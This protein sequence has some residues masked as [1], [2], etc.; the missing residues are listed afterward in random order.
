MNNQRITYKQLSMLKLRRRHVMVL[1]NDGGNTSSAFAADNYL[2]GTRSR[3]DQV[4][5]L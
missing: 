5:E 1:C 4:Y 3:I 2:C